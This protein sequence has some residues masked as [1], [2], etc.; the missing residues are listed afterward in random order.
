[1]GRQNL[2]QDKP[3]LAQFLKNMH[4]TEEQLADLML[5]V[6]Q[7]DGDVAEVTNEWMNEHE[8]LINSWIPEGTD[9]M[10]SAE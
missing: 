2:E 7:S 4:F 9:T 10:A 1:M 6:E 3:E 8:E 5:T